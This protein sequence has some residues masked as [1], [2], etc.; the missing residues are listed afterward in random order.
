[1]LEK[2]IR[3]YPDVLSKEERKFLRTHLRL[4]EE[5]RGFLYLLFKV[6]KNPLKTRPVVSY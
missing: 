5:P 1:M 6:Y 3:T 4:N 2:W